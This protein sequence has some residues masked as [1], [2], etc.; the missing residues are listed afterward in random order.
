[1]SSYTLAGSGMGHVTQIDLGPY[2][3]SK[4]L[5]NKKISI[6]VHTANGGYVIR[7]TQDYRTE[8]DMYIIS[9]N[10]DLGQELGKIITHYTLVK[11]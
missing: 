7:V 10:Q 2:D 9:D 3:N 11:P 6:D 8:E 5:P 4:K 1:M